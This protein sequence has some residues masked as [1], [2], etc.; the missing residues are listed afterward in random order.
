[1]RKFKL[2]IVLSVIFGSLFF[3]PNYNLAQTNSKDSYTIKGKINGWK[4]TVCYFGNNYGDKKYVKDTTRIDKNG[5]FVFSGKEKLPGGMY[6]IVFPNKV[7]YEFI[8]DKEQNFS[9]E[10][11]TADFTKNMKIKGSEDNTMFYKFQMFISTKQKEAEPLR[12][13]VA[14]LRED[15]AATSIKKDSIKIIQDKLSAI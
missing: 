1:M 9:M 10:T 5:N 8:V 3:L 11:D 6:L 4:D 2:S 12:K 15:T 13:T 14:K 7:Y